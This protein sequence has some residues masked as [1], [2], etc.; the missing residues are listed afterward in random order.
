MKA[1]DQKHINSYCQTG[2]STYESQITQH[3][4]P[5]PIQSGRKA[6]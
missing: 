3:V 2:A 4:N 5:L 1:T 6:L